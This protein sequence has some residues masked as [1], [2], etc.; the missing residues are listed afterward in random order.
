MKGFPTRQNPEFTMIEFYQA[1]EDYQDL[2]DFTEELLRHLCDVSWTSS[3]GIPMAFNRFA[4]PFARLTI[5]EAI[6]V[7]HPQLKKVD[8]LKPLKV[9]ELYCL[10][11]FC[12]QRERWSRKATNDFI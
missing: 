8:N 10:N 7:Y 12:I 1:Y 9:A 2:M 3:V 6:L 11:W 5:K 4:K